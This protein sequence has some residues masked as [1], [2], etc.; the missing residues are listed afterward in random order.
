AARALVLVL[1][2]HGGVQA[3]HRAAR[4]TGRAP[5]LLD[6]LAHRGAD[7]AGADGAD[8]EDRAVAAHLAGDHRG[9]G[10][11]DVR[12]GQALDAREARHVLGVG[13][14]ARHVD[15]ARLDDRVA[16]LRDAIVA[17]R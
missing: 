3:A 10:A 12:A 11:V 8:L 17:A 9:D 5:R 4:E 13:R 15:Q 7:G 2:A 6:R 16:G 1:H 14:G